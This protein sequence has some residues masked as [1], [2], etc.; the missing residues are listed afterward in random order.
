MFRV[1]RRHP[2]SVSTRFGHS[3]VLTYAFP[4]EILAPLVPRGLALDVY[5]APDGTEHAFVAVGIVS[6]LGLRPSALPAGCGR[7]FLLTGYRIFTTFRTPQGRTMRGLRILRSDTDRWTM[8]LCG[9]LLTRYR[10]RLARIRLDVAGS[11]LVAS[12]DSRDEQAD[13]TVVADLDSRPAPLPAGSPFAD[14][15]AARRFA[16]PLPYTFDYEAATHSMIIVK[17]RRSEWRPQPVTVDVRR[18]TYFRHGPF[19][20]VRP[21]LANAFHV[22]DLDYGWRR[23]SRRTLDGVQR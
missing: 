9:N 16:G 10:Y 17:A 23:G 12:V 11:R 14:A 1:L 3:L 18:M 7:D 8:V 20:G 4:Q 19:A 5:A 6:A 22:A 13:L 15:H 2:L 21:V